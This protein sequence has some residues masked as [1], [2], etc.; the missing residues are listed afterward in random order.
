M[1]THTNTRRATVFALLGGLMMLATIALVGCM[2]GPEIDLDVAA[3]RAEHKAMAGPYLRYV[4]ADAN[5]DE[6]EKARRRN[7][8]ATQDLRI[9]TLEEA[10]Q[11]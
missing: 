1:T 6:M 7:T 4:E 11:R 8:V 5:L 3:Q 10:V 9:R 2:G